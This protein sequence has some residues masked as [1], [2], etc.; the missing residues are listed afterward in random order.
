MGSAFTIVKFCRLLRSSSSERDGPPKAGAEGREQGCKAAKIGG[1]FDLL[2]CTK[3][4]EAQT[5]SLPVLSMQQLQ[6]LNQYHCIDSGFR[7]AVYPVVL[8][9][10]CIALES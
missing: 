8:M 1:C 2:L 5:S 7:L 10:A 4:K 9:V 6:Y 3:T